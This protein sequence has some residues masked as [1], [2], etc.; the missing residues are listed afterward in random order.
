MV[1][2]VGN[3]SLDSYGDVNH[4]L[5]HMIGNREHGQLVQL[6]RVNAPVPV[7]AAL[8]TSPVISIPGIGLAA[9]YANGDAF[10]TTFQI[11]APPVG[12]IVEVKFFD[13]DF[14]GID[15]EIWCFSEP[16]TEQTD[17]AAFSVADT[18]I[19]NVIA[20]FVISTWRT[21]TASKVGF[22]AN[23]PADYV[24][25]GDILYCQIKTLGTDN[26][27][28]GAEPRVRFVFE[29]KMVS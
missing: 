11:T 21:A 4:K 22:T 1:Q 29:P 7:K 20:V 18:D 16:P 3:L 10:G 2:Q 27:A 26:I 5:D 17:N 8:V 14:E 6:D 15:K 19:V 24:L 13:L 23:T 25:P 12:K 9:A 28:A